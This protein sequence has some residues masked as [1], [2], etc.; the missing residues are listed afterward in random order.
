MPHL[1]SL[2]ALSLILLSGLLR[3]DELT[4]YPGTSE[5]QTRL[6]L[7]RDL[8]SDDPQKVG[9]AFNHVKREP[10][11]D[12]VALLLEA[13]W[14]RYRPSAYLSPQQVS[15]LRDSNSDQ[16]F[17]VEALNWLL[18][19]KIIGKDALVRSSL[20]LLADQI[21]HSN[22]PSLDVKKSARLVLK[23]LG[24]PDTCP[25]ALLLGDQI[26]DVQIDN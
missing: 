1:K 6:K 5:E 10:T 24:S 8:R 15:K 26:L 4:V 7:C 21:L 12:S 25:V 17:R 11:H 13:L 9:S 20:I 16:L 18:R 2:V 23:K 14:L 3:A 22:E 19:C